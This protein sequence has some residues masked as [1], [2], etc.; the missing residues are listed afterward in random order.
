MGEGGR[1]FF[2]RQKVGERK[3]EREMDREN[4]MDR[5]KVFIQ[6]KR[7]YGIEPDYPWNDDN[8]VL[9]HPEN[10][11]WFAVILRVGRDKL[12]LLGEGLADVINVKC[13]PVLIGSLR[14]RQ[15]FHPAYHMNKDQWISIRLDGS[16]PDSQ[17]ED[18][19]DLSYR[20]TMVVKK[21]KK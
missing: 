3:R 14:T 8:A 7:K 9:R 5:E 19:I 17:V 13:E 21:R 16:V 12:G 2:G 11:K 1:C 6:V 4:K 15:G 18:L 20:L 10:R